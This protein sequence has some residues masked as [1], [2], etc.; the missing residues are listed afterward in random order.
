MLGLA[1]IMSA[2]QKVK[3][4]P[5]NWLMHAVRADVTYLPMGRE[6]DD[7]TCKTTKKKKLPKKEHGIFEN[8]F[9]YDSLFS[10]SGPHF[11][12][13]SGSTYLLLLQWC[14]YSA[15]LC[16]WVLLWQVVWPMWKC[17]LHRKH[18]FANRDL[19][20]MTTLNIHQCICPVPIVLSCKYIV[21]FTY[22]CRKQV[23]HHLRCVQT[24]SFIYTT[25]FTTTNKMVVSWFT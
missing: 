14:F 11:K 10:S 15:L 4:E 16:V 7:S 8:W 21:S 5:E 25:L 22:N 1:V 9:E 17:G 12:E 2:S 3:Q 18:I 23:F 24:A 20:K 13:I 6:H 19:T